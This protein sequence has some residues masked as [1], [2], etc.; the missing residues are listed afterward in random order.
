MKTRAGHRQFILAALTISISTILTLIV[1]EMLARSIV[2]QPTYL[3]VP[4]NN[5]R[6]IYEL[7][8]RHQEINSFGMRQEELDPSMLH[9]YF[10]IA[11]IGDS[12]AYSVNSVRRE[13]SFPA[14]LE[15]HLKA[16][17]GKNIKVLNFGVP[18]YNMTQELEVLRVK[19]LQFRPDLVILQYCIND[20]HV[21]NYIQPKY[22]WLN[23]AIYQS[24]LV[25]RGW[26]K[27]LYSDFGRR[28]VLSYVEEYLPDLLLYS[29]GLVGTPL[30]RE[31]DPAHHPHPPRSRD[32][33]PARYH[34]FIGWDNVK[35]DVQVFGRIAKDVGMLAL[36]TGFI[37][38]DNRDLYEAAGFQVYTFSQIFRELN[39]QEYGYNP[40]NTASHFSDQGADFIGKALANFINEKFS[41]S[42][43]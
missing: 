18:G 4:S 43:R 10:V 22:V 37:K 11:V 15:H 19:A 25:S 24:V 3:Y 8:P 31:R 12:H 17:T 36:A 5:F 28:Y 16:L 20:E 34:D 13:D 39:M 6:L 41:L 7:N 30:A 35:R 29:P 38:D 33:V 32:Q 42:R 23:R 40:A 27:L 26:Q 2:T 1:L 9:D 21:S 14:R